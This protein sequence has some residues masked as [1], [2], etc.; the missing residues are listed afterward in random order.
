MQKF[1]EA[2]STVFSNFSDS[3]WD[4]GGTYGILHCLNPLRLSYVKR[5]LLVHGRAIRSLKWLDLGCGG[6][7]LAEPLCRLGGRVTGIDSDQGSIECARLHALSQQLSITYHVGK[8]E[9]Y[10]DRFEST[11]E[12]VTAFEVIEHVD[13]VM[14]FLTCCQKYLKPGGYLFLS[15]MNRTWKSY[16]LGIVM[17]ESILK[18]VPSGMHD[19]SLFLKP[20]ELISK[21]I[22]LG[23]EVE[24][25]QGYTYE[26]RSDTWTFNGD[27]DVNYMVTARLPL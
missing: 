14:A 24:N 8:A 4:P 21:L 9:D 7:L 12:C 15:T 13:D 5:Q 19:W 23:F 10:T 18:W 22:S 16:L 17:A 3:W 20:S 2:S 25:I 1:L 26:V 11:F 6:G 27:L